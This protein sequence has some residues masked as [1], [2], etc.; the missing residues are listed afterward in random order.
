MLHG[1]D[2]VVKQL[3][4]WSPAGP[5][6]EPIDVIWAYRKGVKSKLGYVKRK[7]NA[8]ITLIRFIPEDMREPIRLEVEKQRLQQGGC[9]VAK[10]VNCIPNPKVITAYVK[11]ELKKPKPTTIVMPDGTPA[12]YYEDEDETTDETQEG[13]WDE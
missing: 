7:D 1:V 11:G 13:E 12:G 4:G 6:T 10:H 8:P 5:K 2:I 9:S 3:S